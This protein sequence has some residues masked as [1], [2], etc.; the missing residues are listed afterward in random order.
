VWDASIRQEVHVV[1]EVLEGAFSPELA[2]TL[3]FQALQAH[4]DVPRTPDDVL[5]LCRG[6]LGAVVEERVG[7]TIRNMVIDRL[8]QVLVRGSRDGTD[9]PIELD[10]DGDPTDTMVIPV[11]FQEPVSVVVLAAAEDFGRHLLA[12]LGPER[13]R[14]KTV[15]SEDALRKAVFT[16]EPLLV[17]I[18]ATQ[19][20]STEP[21][22]VVTSLKALPDSVQPVVWG[23]DMEYGA[24]L[25]RTLVAM[26]VTANGLVQADGI[27][28]LL[29]LVLSRY[30]QEQKQ[31]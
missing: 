31:Q 9:I 21:P 10:L 19:P 13:V 8:E 5:A 7:A 25:I 18:D 3:M 6:P 4:G 29:D 1:R 16:A 22:V 14:V 11:V 15:T 27:A 20:P 28:P 24:D 30:H 26:G 2:T 12:A 23:T 17:L